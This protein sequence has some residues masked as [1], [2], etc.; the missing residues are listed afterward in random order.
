MKWKCKR[1]GAEFDPNKGRLDELY[2]P[3]YCK[4]SPSPWEPI[5][6]KNMNILDKTKTYLIG[7]MEYAD[8]RKWRE[9][10]TSFLH[11]MGVT[12]FDPYKKPFTNAPQEDEQTHSKMAK[13][14]NGGDFDEVHEHF[15]RVRAFDL[16]MVDRSDFI[17]CYINP[18]VPTFGTIEEL[19]TSV[20]MKR[21]TFVVVEGGKAKTPLWIM[22]M[23]PHKYIYN[24][25]EE[26]KL[27]LTNIDQ[28]VKSIDSDRW[29]LFKP[30]LR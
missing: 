7:P 8:G 10:M 26:L 23:M 14:M 2:H 3:C 4:E 6:N 13:L 30:E 9:D 24:S 16:S 25:F 18:K 11:Q 29:R 22:G 19:V 15:K 28:G 1:C 21:P 17:I 27:M 5:E 12:V 20:R